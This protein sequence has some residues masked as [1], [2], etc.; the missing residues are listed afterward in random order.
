[1]AMKEME[2]LS[3]LLRGLVLERWTDNDIMEHV[4]VKLPAPVFDR[5]VMDLK[6]EMPST[7]ADLGYDI[8]GLGDSFTFGAV[9]FRRVHGV[10]WSL[11]RSYARS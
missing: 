6:R 7:T 10:S 2:Q 11:P 3:S 1:M 5:L 9:K 4:E 8:A